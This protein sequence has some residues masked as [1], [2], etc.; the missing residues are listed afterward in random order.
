[1]N[2]DVLI[3][4]MWIRT[5]QGQIGVDMDWQSC[6]TLVNIRLEADWMKDYQQKIVGPIESGVRG[7]IYAGDLD[8]ICNW[9]GNQAWSLAL[10]WKGQKKFASTDPVEWKVDGKAAGTIRQAKGMSNFT[11]V[12]V[13]DGGHMVPM[14]KPPAALQ[15]VNQFITDTLMP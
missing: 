6:D 7:L 4:W 15:L 11:F 2:Y 12:R 10:P 3:V 1:M 13:Y 14:D 8:F 9:L 5:V